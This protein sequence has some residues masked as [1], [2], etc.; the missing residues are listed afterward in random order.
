MVINFTI[1][2]DVWAIGQPVEPSTLVK[3]AELNG[4]TKTRRYF[5]SKTVERTHDHS[6][7][8]FLQTS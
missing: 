3:A 1:D 5:P 2:P 7:L 6:N 4:V 8:D